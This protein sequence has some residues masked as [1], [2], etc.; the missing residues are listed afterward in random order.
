MTHLR[1]YVV[2]IPPVVEEHGI[3]EHGCNRKKMELNILGFQL[4]QNKAC[5]LGRM[6]KLLS[7]RMV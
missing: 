3:E 5:A 1:E 4:G 7:L 2:M 6:R